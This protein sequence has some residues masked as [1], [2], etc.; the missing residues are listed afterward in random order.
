MRRIVAGL[1]ISLDGV[2][3]DRTGWAFGYF[4]DQMWEMIRAG[5]EEADAILLGRR[6]YTQFAEIW[7]NQS[8]DV[9]MADFL[10][11]APKYVV[12]SQLDTLKWANSHLIH[13]DLADELSKLKQQPGKNIQVPGSPSLVRSLL[14]DGLLDELALLICPIVVG[15]GMRLFEDVTH[16]LRLKLV[17]SVTLANGALATRYAPAGV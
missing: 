12:S 3:E 9:P 17:Q 5:I 1:Y 8:S 10:N 13:G 15:S 4:N 16:E 14:Q 6:T 2:V 11:H 7:P